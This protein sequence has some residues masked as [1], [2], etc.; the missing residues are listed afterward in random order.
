M[1]NLL[2]VFGRSARAA[3]LAISALVAI[4]LF[5]NSE[6]HAAGGGYGPGIGGP[7]GAPGGFNNIVTTQ[8]FNGTGGTV[9][10]TVPGCQAKLTVPDGAFDQPIQVVVTAPDLKGINTVLPQLGFAAD[11]AIAGVGVSVD[12][13][14]GEPVTTAFVHPLTLT[15]TCSGIGPGD[16]LV[17]FISLTSAATLQDAV[18]TNGSVTVSLTADPDFAV[19]APKVG[20]SASAAASAVP[21][22]ATSASATA[23]ASPPTSSSSPP[24][25]VEGEHFT[26]GSG[27]SIVDKTLLGTLAAL[28]VAAG[29]VALMMRRR[30]ADPFVPKHSAPRVR[31]RSRR[32][33]VTT[34][35]PKHER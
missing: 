25:I 7:A 28:V 27:G 6:A 1:S 10:A 12:D 4:S 19:L 23:S 32:V 3:I 8:V 13:A 33:S 35:T 29:F 30:R 17:E 11:T 34:L 20:Q 14:A 24:A 5:G 2:V 21:S 15:L 18:F 22:A 31:N 16:L 9:T 26:K